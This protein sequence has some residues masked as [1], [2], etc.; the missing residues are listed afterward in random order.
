M[1]AAKHCIMQANAELHQSA[2]A[3]QKKRF[4]EEIAR[5][6]VLWLLS[7]PTTSTFKPLAYFTA[8]SLPRSSL[9]HAADLV[10]NVASRYDEYVS[11]KDLS[12]RINRALTSAKKDNDFIYNDRVPEVKDLEHIGK[13]ALVKAAPITAPLSQK[14]TG[15]TARRNKR[16]TVDLQAA[17]RK[18]HLFSQLASRLGFPSSKRR[19]FGLTDFSV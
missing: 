16:R 19:R 1:L 12:D 15:E 7:L 2:L 6:Q 4:G 8:F 13:A 9:Q 14:F 11:V 17:L 10:K 18:A 3:K 5:L